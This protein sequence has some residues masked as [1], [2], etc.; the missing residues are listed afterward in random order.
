MARVGILCFIRFSWKAIRAAHN[1][2][3]KVH[4]KVQCLQSCPADIKNS[5]KRIHLFVFQEPGS[6][7]FLTFV[8]KSWT[9]TGCSHEIP[10]SSQI[11]GFYRSCCRWKWRL[12][13]M[14]T[15]S[16]SQVRPFDI[17][18]PRGMYCSMVLFVGLIVCWFD[19]LFVGLIVCL[20][21]CLFVSRCRCV[22][23]C[24]CVAVFPNI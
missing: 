7:A 2:P 21:A 9:V 23:V 14:P 8:L 12:M 19:C 10:S 13:I 6:W 18:V 15:P 20:F 17:D 5:P 22:C 4:T 3:W 11:D 1:K 16:L 24:V